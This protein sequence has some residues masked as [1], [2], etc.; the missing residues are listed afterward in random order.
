MLREVKG[1]LRNKRKA[2]AVAGAVL[3]I[4]L[5]FIEHEVWHALQPVALFTMA[6]AAQWRAHS[7]AYAQPKV[8]SFLSFPPSPCFFWGVFFGVVVSLVC[9]VRCRVP[10]PIFHA[11]PEMFLGLVGTSQTRISALV[12]LT[13]IILLG[14]CITPLTTTTRTHTHTHTHTRLRWH[15]RSN[16][17]IRTQK[18]ALHC[19]GSSLRGCLRIQQGRRCTVRLIILMHALHWRIGCLSPQTKLLLHCKCPWWFDIHICP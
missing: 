7:Q 16:W 10:L 15:C 11:Y 1:A 5:F 17:L 12:M 4:L 18:R 9:C 19:S 13:W 8:A 6:E 2:A 14:N 3:V